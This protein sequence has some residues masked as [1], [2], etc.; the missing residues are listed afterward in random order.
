MR[1]LNR[2]RRDTLPFGWLDAPVR[3]MAGVL[4][5]FADDTSNRRPVSRGN[6][7]LPANCTPSK[8]RVGVRMD[9]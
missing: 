9:E 4:M 8:T 2:P 1:R 6:L 7:Q 5:T 3:K